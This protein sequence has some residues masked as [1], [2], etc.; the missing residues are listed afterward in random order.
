M[1]ARGKKLGFFSLVL[2]SQI[3]LITFKKMLAGF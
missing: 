1:E 3:L 2:L